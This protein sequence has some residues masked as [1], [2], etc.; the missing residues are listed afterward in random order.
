MRQSKTITDLVRRE[1]ARNGAPSWPK[2]RRTQ[3]RGSFQNT[4]VSRSSVRAAAADDA[5]A[6][7]LADIADDSDRDFHDAQEALQEQ[8]ARYFE[9]QQALREWEQRHIHGIS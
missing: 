8:E 1:N 3:S 7:A 5:I 4:G 9:Q 2:G 6:E